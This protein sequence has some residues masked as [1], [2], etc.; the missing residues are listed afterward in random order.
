MFVH[1]RIS[2]DVR[3][4]LMYPFNL[5]AVFIKMRLHGEMIPLGEFTKA[6]HEFRSCGW[7]ETRGDDESDIWSDFLGLHNQLF[8]ARKTGVRILNQVVWRISIHV[9]FANHWT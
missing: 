9:D 7:Y 3:V 4:K 8:G 1:F 2:W 6:I 5:I